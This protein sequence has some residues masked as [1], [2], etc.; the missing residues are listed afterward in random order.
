MENEQTDR[1]KY[2][3][4]LH[5]QLAKVV[6]GQS[7]EYTDAGKLIV[8]ILSADVNQFTKLVLTDKFIND[9][10]GYVDARAK[11]NYAASLLGRLKSL[12]NP[13]KEKEIRESIEAAKNDEPAPEVPTDG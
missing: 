3:V 2:L 8:E 1:E 9:H 12:D 5:A 10:Q 11:A 4:G 13:A 6:A 7:F